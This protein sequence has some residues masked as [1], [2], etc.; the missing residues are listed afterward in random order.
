MCQARLLLIKNTHG[1]KKSPV[2]E[3][4]FTVPI[5]TAR[6][7]YNDIRRVSTKVQNVMKY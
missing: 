5:T 4:F 3:L 6:H 2:L 1:K 7:I